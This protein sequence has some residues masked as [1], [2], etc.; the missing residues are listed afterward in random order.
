MT[1]FERVRAFHAALGIP[2]EP[3]P[4][5]PMPERVALRCS[6]LHEEAKEAIQA[7][8]H[9]SLAEIAQELADVLVVTY[10]AALEFGI[11]L[12][13][14]MAEVMAA[15]MRKAGGPVRADGKILKPPG[16]QA[17]DVASALWG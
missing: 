17:P 15:N 8:A 9:G 7:M 5:V 6:L 14:V 1:N 10:G 2:T 4:T 3:A 11:P 13:D 12:D 16:W